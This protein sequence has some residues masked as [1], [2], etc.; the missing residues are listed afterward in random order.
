MK[1]IPF[2][3]TGT[4]DTKS[5]LLMIMNQNPRG[6]MLDEMRRRITIMNQVE[7]GKVDVILKDDDHK[8]VCE[9]M[10]SFPFGIAHKD[11]L[12]AIDAIM[13]ADE[14]P[15]LETKPKAE[16]QANDLTA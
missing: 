1:L 7:E 3:T 14:P 15:M 2:K 12:A 9:A 16:A 5:L 11:L 8:L 4:W 13:E 10:K 6:M